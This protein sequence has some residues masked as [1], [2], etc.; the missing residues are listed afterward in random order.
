MRFDYAVEQYT[1]YLLKLSY[2]NVRDKQTAE[3]IV[4]DVFIKL[5]EKFGDI[6]PL[7]HTK[8]YLVT[9]TMNRCR[10]YFKSWHYRKIQLTEVF[11]RE[12][13]TEPTYEFTEDETQS[14]LIQA[15]LNLPINYREVI[16]LYYYDEQSTNE[17][18]KTLSIPVGTV[19]TRLQRAR[20]LLKEHIKDAEVTLHA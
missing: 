13:K 5:Y 12:A 6:I 15:I 16:V 11:S 20:Q 17:I 14:E 8:S 19:K 7:E 1:T 3:D 18:A 9:M 2:L 10:D 4:Q